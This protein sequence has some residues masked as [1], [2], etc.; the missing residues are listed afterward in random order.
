VA[1]QRRAVGA[2]AAITQDPRGIGGTVVAEFRG[3]GAGRGSDL[4]SCCGG[5][6]ETRPEPVPP[7]HLARTRRGR[8]PRA[9]MGPARLL[10]CRPRRNN[11]GVARGRPRNSRGVPRERAR[12]GPRSPELLRWA[13]CDAERCGRP[14]GTPGAAVGRARRSAGRGG[15]PGGT[16]AAR[17]RRSAGW[18]PRDPGRGGAWRG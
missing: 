13:G 5:A 1:R 17:A 6:G 14:G 7:R 2:F 12:A 11:S 3:S 9:A 16:R 4:L 10:W 18:H 15:G 8:P